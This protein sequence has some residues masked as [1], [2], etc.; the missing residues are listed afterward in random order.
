MIAATEMQHARLL[1]GT[2]TETANVSQLGQVTAA[3]VCDAARAAV[4]VP[5]IGDGPMLRAIT[6]TT[7]VRRLTASRIVE[8]RRRPLF[9][10]FYGDNNSNR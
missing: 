3:I 2:R 7:A 8:G 6:A 10:N 9:V 4:P 5:A 1:R